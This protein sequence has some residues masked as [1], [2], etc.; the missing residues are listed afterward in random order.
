[1]EEGTNAFGDDLKIKL[2]AKE[3]LIVE[4]NNFQLTGNTFEIAAD[5]VKAT[6]SG[7]FLNENFSLI[8]NGL[9]HPSDPDNKRVFVN[10]KLIVNGSPSNV[11]NYNFEVNGNSAIFGKLQ[12]AASTINFPLTINW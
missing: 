2:W 5:A 12:I 1:M 4:S 3:N 6:G 8:M 7:K 11:S 10:N 9:A